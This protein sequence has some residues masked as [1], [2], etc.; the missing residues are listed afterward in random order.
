MERVALKSRYL[1][2]SKKREKQEA[3]RSNRPDTGRGP[4]DKDSRATQVKEFSGSPG[5]FDFKGIV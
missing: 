2:K 3:V 4:T 1:Q 5:F